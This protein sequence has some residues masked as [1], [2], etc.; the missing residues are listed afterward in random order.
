MID[1][2]NKL[3]FSQQDIESFLE[4]YRSKSPLYFTDTGLDMEA[5]VPVV[6][7]RIRRAAS[8]TQGIT[9][10]KDDCIFIC[11]LPKG[12]QGQRRQGKP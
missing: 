12:R 8:E 3:V 9:I 11:T 10:S 1:F 2:P 6:S 4:Y 7:E 5:T